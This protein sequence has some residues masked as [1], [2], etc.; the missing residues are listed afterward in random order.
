V[1]FAAN[2]VR[3]EIRAMSAYHVR[4][5]TGLI[6]LDAMENPYPWPDGMEEDWLDYLRGVPLNRYPDPSATSLKNCLRGSLEAAGDNEILL[7][8]GSDELIQII[9]LSAVGRDGVIVAPAPSFVM[10]EMTARFVGAKFVGVPLS[11]DFAID[12][13]AMLRAIRDHRPSVVFLAYPNNPT[14]NLFDRGAIGRIISET[15]G[16]VVVDEAYHAFAGTSFVDELAGYDNLIVMR[17]LSKLGLAGLRLGYMIGPAELLN[18]FEKVRMP[19]NISALTQR[20]AEFALGR[21]DVFEHQASRIVA[22]RDRVYAYLDALEG[23]APYPSKTNFILFRSS[24]LDA[25]ALYD[26]LVEHGILVKGFGD[27][28]SGLD[29]CLRVTVGTRR[30]N[31]V[32]MAALAAILSGR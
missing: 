26:R 32:F 3:P 1:T 8:N 31:D 21:L 7:G 16:L 20:T 23:V 30:E 18:E 11:P 17:T 22:E 19:Y 15:R 14:G 2:S 29:R 6:K 9:Q 27:H 25:P 10:Y 24:L 4:D 13:D 12:E 28:G 5:S